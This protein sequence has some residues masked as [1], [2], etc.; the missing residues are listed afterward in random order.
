MNDF[1][2][3]HG[4]SQ[5][6]GSHGTKSEFNVVWTT[7][8]L[9][10]GYWIEARARVLSS[11]RSANELSAHSCDGG[12]CKSPASQLLLQLQNRAPGMNNYWLSAS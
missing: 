12:R 10:E 7:G 2:P 5:N 9:L 1:E 3:F 8:T 11:L 6:D 4:V